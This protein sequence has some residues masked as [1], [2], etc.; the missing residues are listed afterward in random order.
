MALFMRLAGA[1]GVA[2][3]GSITPA[4]AVTLG[5]NL[6]V[7]GDFETTDGTPGLTVGN[8]NG[9]ALNSLAGNTGGSS[10]DV[11]DALPGWTSPSGNGIEVQTN[12]TLTGNNT[13]DSMASYTPS[14]LGQHY[15]ELDS[16]RTR[17][18]PNSNSSMRQTLSLDTGVYHFSFHYSPRRNSSAGDDNLIRYSIEGS[19]D[20]SPAL[21]TGEVSGPLNGTGTTVG[22]WTKFMATFNVLFDDTVVDFTFSADGRENEHGG[23]IDNVALHQDLDADPFS[24]VIPLPA[25]LLMIASAFGLAGVYRRFAKSA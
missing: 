9:Q 23:F 15:I 24:A 17:N 19:P 6:I 5:P 21:V 11:Y 1:C 10:W 25:P 20:I 8:S 7:N 2:F 18:L 13:V 14:L 12:G 4:F 16:E 3:I 22:N